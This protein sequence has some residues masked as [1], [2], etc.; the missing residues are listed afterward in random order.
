MVKELKFIQS[1]HRSSKRDYLARMKTKSKL[2][3][4]SSEIWEGLLGWK[5]KICT[6]DTNI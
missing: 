6:E 4:Y 3:D 5:S 1:L 2:Y